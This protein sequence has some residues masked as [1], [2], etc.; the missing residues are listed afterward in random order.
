[1]SQIATIFKLNRKNFN[2]AR[3]LSLVVATFVPL[4]VLIAL[5]EEQYFLSVIYGALLVGL[6]EPGGRYADRLVHMAVFAVA[7]AL[8]T[9]LGFGIG[10]GPWGW[11]VL[12]AFVVTLAAGL[13]VKYGLHR[14]TA[15]Y[16]LNIWFVI[17][18]TLP[19]V[20]QASHVHVGAWSQ[21]LAFLIGSALAIAVTFA[22]W[23]A[24][25]RTAQPQPAPDL[26]PDSIEPVPLTRPVIAFAVLR[27]A[28]VAITVAIAF[29][30]HLSSADWM[31]IAAIVAMKP[32]LQ[33]SLLT[34]EQR[35]AG[36]ILGAAVAALFLLTVD[37]KTALEVIIVILCA[38]AGAIMTVNY[39]WYCTA[40]AAL[41]LIAVDLPHPSNHAEEARRIGFTFAG[42]GIAI[43]VLL[44][45]GLLAKRQAAA[46]QPPQPAAHGG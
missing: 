8:V 39:A 5:H 41:V 43:L 18:I 35:L 37:S 9:A 45:G 46:A 42:V 6:T 15:A 27:A 12:A 29:G 2:L 25:G 33:Q 14:F 17:A 20:Y 11:V 26:I 21:A 44:L 32:S 28:A 30:L 23:L 7:G 10:G 19:G 4:I 24:R 31:P 36:A 22:V 13:A 3:G 38:L 40:V 1:V 34:A 16:L